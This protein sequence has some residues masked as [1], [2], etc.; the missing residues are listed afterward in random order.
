MKLRQKNAFS[1]KKNIRY[2]KLVLN[3]STFL[4]FEIV[5]ELLWTK[6]YLVS[7]DNKLYLGAELYSNLYKKLNEGFIK[8]KLFNIKKEKYFEFAGE[9]Y[10]CIIVLFDPY[11]CVCIT[12]NQKDFNVLFLVDYFKILGKKITVNSHSLKFE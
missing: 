2:N 7:K 8:K 12:K 9:Q 11:V 10:K 3:E 6:V 4:K 1:L 5:N